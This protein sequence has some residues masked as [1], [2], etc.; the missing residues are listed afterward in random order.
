MARTR[1]TMA[2]LLSAAALAVA[3]APVATANPSPPTNG[4]N[5]AGQSGQCTGKN[6]DRPASCQSQG[7]PGNQP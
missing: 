2:A 6:A 3:V 4:G 5:G 1:K 7:G